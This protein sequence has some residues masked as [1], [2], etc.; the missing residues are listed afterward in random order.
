MNLRKNFSKKELKNFMLVVLRDGEKLIV[1]DDVIIDESH[2]FLQLSSYDN[3]LLLNN[4]GN[5]KFD[6]MKIYIPKHSSYRLTFDLNYR[7]CIWKRDEAKE[8]TLSEICKA[9]GYDV[10]IIKDKE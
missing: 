6:I 2:E 4:R 7:D 9:L 10:K 8:M 1:C 3:E 5:D